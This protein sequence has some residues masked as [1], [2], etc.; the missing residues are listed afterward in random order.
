MQA[1]DGVLGGILIR[2]PST[3]NYDYDLGNLFLNDWSYQTASQEY[4]Y[5][6][7]IGPPT[8]DTGLINGTVMNSSTLGAYFEQTV[9]S[10]SSYL[11]RLV[12]GAADTMFDFSIDNHTLTV[13]AADFVPIVPYETDVV[14]IGMGQR[15]DIVVTANQAAVA[16]DFW[17]RAVPDSF[18][19]NNYNPDAIK[20]IL[21]YG[22]MLLLRPLHTH[23][24]F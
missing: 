10:G 13:M 18:C 20:G 3:A 21:H 9:E 16:S 2:G 6:Q 5:T 11:L 24:L 8:A 17:I 19:S 7:Y 12:N 1:W 22:G 15:Y 23:T 14:A 4:S